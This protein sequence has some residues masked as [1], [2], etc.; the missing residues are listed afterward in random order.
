MWRCTEAKGGKFSRPNA[1]AWLLA[2]LQC[3]SI[4]AAATCRPPW[5]K[6]PAPASYPPGQEELCHRHPGAAL[7]GVEKEGVH[8]A[9]QRRVEGQ[10]LHA[11]GRREG[12]A[13]QK[14]EGQV[15][16]GGCAGV[17][18]GEGRVASGRTMPRLQQS[19]LRTNDTGAWRAMGEGGG[20]PLPTDPMQE[21]Q[22]GNG[23]AQLRSAR[24]AVT[25]HSGSS[26]GNAEQGGQ[27]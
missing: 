1:I 8:G 3:S 22:H 11:G 6:L 12:R 7:L 26:S 21:M 23:Q 5:C 19:M 13:Q 24:A 16:G 17:R 14:E 27:P 20:Q 9:A 4:T 2:G 25:R 18:E 15:G 10:R